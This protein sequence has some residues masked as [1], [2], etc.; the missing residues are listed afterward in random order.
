MK[1]VRCVCVWLGAAW[2]EKGGEC[3]RGLGL[4][5]INTVRTGGML[6]VC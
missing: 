1:C 4:G 6:D 5:L 3:M 2:V